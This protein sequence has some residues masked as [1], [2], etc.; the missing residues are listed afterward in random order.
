MISAMLRAARLDATFFEQVEAD[1]SSMGLARGVVTMGGLLFGLG[2]AV[3]IMLEGS[4]VGMGGA[5]M[6]IVAGIV[7][8]WVGWWLWSAVALW[9]GTTV[10]FGPATEADLGQLLRTLG[11]A[12]APLALG[13]LQ[14]LPAVGGA[15]AATALLWTLASA[16]VAV[17]QA[18]DFTTAR[19]VATLI[20]GWLL[21]AV[22]LGAL[23]AWA[24]MTAT[25]VG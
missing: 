14:W 12:T 1:P 16:T 13:V 20:I 15:L 19:A 25:P 8:A 10:T 18:L 23:F 17:R 11:F 21:H 3:R 7:A 22:V 2:A 5:A 4:A 9:V 24:W 6:L